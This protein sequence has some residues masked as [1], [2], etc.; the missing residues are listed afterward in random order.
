[1]K[2]T[3]KIAFTTQFW[4]KGSFQ[5]SGNLVS[6]SYGSKD[7]F[8]LQMFS[9][10]LN[11]NSG[12]LSGGIYFSD[13]ILSLN[14][15]EWIFIGISVG[16]TMKEDLYKFWAIISQQ[17]TYS[18]GEW[19]NQDD[20]NYS[21]NFQIDE[22]VF[23]FGPRLD[24][25]IKEVYTTDHFQDLHSLRQLTDTFGQQRYYCFE[26]EFHNY[27]YLLEPG[28]GNGYQVGPDAEECDD[29]NTNDSDGCSSTCSEEDLYEC[30]AGTGIAQSHSCSNTWRNG[31]S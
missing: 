2:S 28:C 20:I 4:Y 17:S 15:S 10:S 16:W 25:F 12:G 19:T 29:G 27:P 18:Y 6:F 7:Y 31:K 23:V 8:R 3:S 24:G 26:G 14:S 21:Y 5:T 9:N 13:A 11:I 1:M 22:K 30:T